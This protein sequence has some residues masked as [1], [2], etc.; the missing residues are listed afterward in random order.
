MSGNTGP[1]PV[2]IART[3]RKPRVAPESS[4]SRSRNAGDAVARVTR[5]R[6]IWPSTTGASMSAGRRRSASGSTVSTP[7]A[8]LSSTTTGRLTSSR[9]CAR[10][11]SDCVSAASCARRMP[12]V[13]TTPFGRPVLPLVNVTSAGA[14]SSTASITSSGGAPLSSNDRPPGTQPLV[15]YFVGTFL[16]APETTLSR[17]AFGVATSARGGHI[18][19]ASSSTFR[20]ADGS[21]NIATAPRR[22]T[23]ISAAYSAALG[24]AKKR[25]PSPGSMP[26][27]RKVAAMRRAD[28]SSS[29]KLVSR[30]AVPLPSMS[31]AA[32]AR[33]ATGPESSSATFMDPV[34]PSSSARDLARD[35]RSLPRAPDGRSLA[36]ARDDNS[37]CARDDMLQANAQTAHNAAAAHPCAR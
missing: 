10:A 24:G 26:S 6:S 33:V 5:S 16:S 12:C 2:T 28:A 1:P 3:S 8:R 13:R 30:R 19:H 15:T 11:A 22:N 23:A 7:F 31:A 17:C 35:S 20:P 9:S 29:A 14:S 18:A 21:T 27:R 37:G 36:D 25:T 32:L 4:A 34:I